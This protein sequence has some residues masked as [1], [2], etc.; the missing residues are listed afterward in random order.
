VVIVAQG[1]TVAKGTVQEL[2]AQAQETD[3]EDA[4]V[5]LAFLHSN[6]S[7]SAILSGVASGS[8]S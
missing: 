6:T 2:M 5:K 4:F 7:N 1:K 3:F 8:L